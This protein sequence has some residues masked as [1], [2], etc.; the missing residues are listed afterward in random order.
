MMI[1]LN[2]CFDSHTPIP[3]KRLLHSSLSQLSQSPSL[4]P[5]ALR[6]NEKEKAELME[7]VKT[8][9]IDSKDQTIAELKEQLA[10]QTQLQREVAL[11]RADKETFVSVIGSLQKEKEQLRNDVANKTQKLEENEKSLVQAR[12]TIEEMKAEL[13]R[14]EQ[15]FV[16]SEIIIA[17]DPNH[18]RVNGTT[19]TNISGRWVGC[20]TK[21]V[22][23]G[24]HRL[25]IKT[26][27]N[28]LIGVIDAAEFPKHLT[29][30][31]HASPKAGLMQNCSGYLYTASKNIVLNTIPQKEQEFSVEADL[32]KRT[33]HFF[34]DGMQQP[35]HFIDIPVPLVFALDPYTQDVPIPIAFWG[36]LELSSVTFQG[37]GHNL[38]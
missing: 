33:L 14:K 1:V 20:F 12:Q 21:P 11:L 29:S 9:P 36:E 18:Y 7:K 23:K 28:T 5:S 38:G 35:H 15:F 31:S 37:T 27:A 6:D 13:A 26:A 19:V 22:S 24:I 34:I 16:S 10:D 25:S 2:E 4:P 30:H 3:N 8:H 32:E 17:F